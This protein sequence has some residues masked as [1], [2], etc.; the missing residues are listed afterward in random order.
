MRAC[1]WI[2][3]CWLNA[4]SNDGITSQVAYTPSSLLNMYMHLI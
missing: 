3:D 2:V 4:K 1:T